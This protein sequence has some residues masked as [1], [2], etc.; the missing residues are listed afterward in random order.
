[1]ITATTVTA[2]NVGDA[3]AVNALLAE[4]LPRPSASGI[5]QPPLGERD[6][7]DSDQPDPADSDQRDP[8]DSDEPDPADSDQRDP[9]DGGE[10]DPAASGEPG[11]LDSGEPDPARQRPARS[12]RC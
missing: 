6:P 8:L 11:P 7:A 3:E 1:M 9:R 4:E 12:G 5:E 2:G 10:P